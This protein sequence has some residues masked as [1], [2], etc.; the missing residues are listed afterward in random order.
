MKTLRL[1]LTFVALA[2]P[3]AAQTVSMRLYYPTWKCV[4]ANGAACGASEMSNPY[5]SRQLLERAARRADH[6]H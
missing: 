3:A 4:F 2:L 5:Y 6:L 1:L